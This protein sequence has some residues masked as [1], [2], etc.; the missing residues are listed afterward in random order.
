M[1][2]SIKS[3]LPLHIST[4]RILSPASFL[5]MVQ[6]A[7]I[8]KS[9]KFVIK[10][11]LILGYFGMMRVSNYLPTS[12]AS[13]HHTVNATISDLTCIANNVIMELRFSK[14]HKNESIYI[15]LPNVS[16]CNLS[17]KYLFNHM[18]ANNNFHVSPNAPLLLFT[19]GFPLCVPLYNK[20]IKFL[21]FNV[22]GSDLGVSSHTLRRSATT[23]FQMAGASTLDLQLQGNWHSNAF[24]TY[25]V[26]T[27][28]SS[29]PVQKA[30]NKIF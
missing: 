1:L 24:L 25:L 26:Q 5:E 21:A 11:A 8:F 7:D 12:A 16:G 20:I 15:V 22:T 19:N 23:Y 6:Y 4:P 27:Q 30:C 9:E 18:C 17:A 10:L 13:Y 28:H 29:S 14:T 2:T 3:T